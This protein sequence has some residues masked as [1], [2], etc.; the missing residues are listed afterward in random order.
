MEFSKKMRLSPRPLL[1]PPFG[2]GDGQAL[3]IDIDL[4][5]CAKHI[6]LRNV[7]QFLSSLVYLVL[8]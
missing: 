7:L 2:P 1:S 3:F 6:I 4:T 5:S 8:Y